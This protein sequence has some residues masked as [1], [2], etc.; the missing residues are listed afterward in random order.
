MFTVGSYYREQQRPTDGLAEPGWRTGKTGLHHIN[1]Q[2][3]IHKCSAI[4]LY[5]YENFS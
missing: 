4:D 3:T 2:C 1:I 5:I